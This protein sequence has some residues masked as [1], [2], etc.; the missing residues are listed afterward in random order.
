MFTRD[1]DIYCESAR[2]CDVLPAPLAIIGSAR[3][4]QE[5]RLTARSPI[6]AGNERNRPILITGRSIS[7]SLVNTS[8]TNSDAASVFPLHCKD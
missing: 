6:R 3:N 4:R 8:N 7:A 1:F 2:G 5:V